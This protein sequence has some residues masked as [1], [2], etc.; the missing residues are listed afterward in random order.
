MLP[1]GSEVMIVQPNRAA[2]G[3]ISVHRPSA[4]PILAAGSLAKK[5]SSEKTYRSPG[6]KPGEP[7]STM[8]LIA[9]ALVMMS[10]RSGLDAVPDGGPTAVPDALAETAGQAKA[11]GDS[12]ASNQPPFTHDSLPRT[13]RAAMAG[14]RSAPT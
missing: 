1:F 9:V 8:L 13:A 4:R 3:S 12:A 2:E 7:M 6:L 10:I 11:Q 5:T 14:V